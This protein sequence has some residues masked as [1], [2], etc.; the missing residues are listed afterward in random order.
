MIYLLMPLIFISASLLITVI[1]S[2]AYWKKLNIQYRLEKIDEIYQKNIELD[3]RKRLSFKKR[4][5]YPIA[6]KFKNIMRSITPQGRRQELEKKLGAVELPF[7]MSVVGWLIF[8]TMFSIAFPVL[9]FLLLKG[10]PINIISK[11]TLLLIFTIACI[12]LPNVMLNNRIKMKEKRIQKQ[13]PD[14][15]DLLTI[16]V[17]AGLSFDGA[18]QH[19]V[20]KDKSE[21]SKEFGRVL[22]EMEFGKTRREALSDMADRCNVPDLKIFISSMIQA[23]QLGISIGRILRIQSDMMREKRMQRAKELALK[24]PVKIIIPLVLFIFPSIFIVILGPALIQIKETLF[25]R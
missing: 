5:I 16:S 24:A 2:L 11:I 9:L 13:L 17:E 10:N 21:L 3:D 18:L 6:Q 15:L 12:L 23:E 22:Q 1:V 20:A 25:K 14:I 4:V 19:I 7:G 8:K